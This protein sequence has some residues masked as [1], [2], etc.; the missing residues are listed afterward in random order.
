VADQ[1]RRGD[2]G[3]ADRI[4]GGAGQADKVIAVGV[5]GV[6]VVDAVIPP[7]IGDADDGCCGQDR[8]PVLEEARAAARVRKDDHGG[9]AGHSLV[10][11]GNHDTDYRFQFSDVYR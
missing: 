8:P 1:H 3:V 9:R 10:Q 5:V 4:G 2:S 7:G 6:R 11:R